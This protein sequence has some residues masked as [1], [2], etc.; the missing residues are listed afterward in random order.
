[1]TPHGKFKWTKILS[2]G[3]K[4]VICTPGI[5]TTVQEGYKSRILECPNPTKFQDF[6]TNQIP[7]KV[8]KIKKKG[9]LCCGTSETPLYL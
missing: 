1:M 9:F 7:Q 8:P 5:Y 3:Q 4:T 6:K 2:D